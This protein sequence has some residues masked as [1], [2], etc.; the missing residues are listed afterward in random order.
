M[1]MG[2]W[3]QRAALVPGKKAWDPE[4]GREGEQTRA[5]EQ[6]VWVQT[7]EWREIG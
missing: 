6:H 7:K 3:T 2:N 1:R 4:G 5:W